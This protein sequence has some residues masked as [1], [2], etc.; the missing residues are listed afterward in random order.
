MRVLASLCNF[1]LVPEPYGMKQVS[2]GGFEAGE[3]SR[4]ICYM[5]KSARCSHNDFNLGVRQ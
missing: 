1:M 3:I 5:I 4:N 2:I